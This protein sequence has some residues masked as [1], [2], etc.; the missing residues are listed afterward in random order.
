L[1]PPAFRIDELAKDYR[2]MKH[3]IFDKPL[4]FEEIME[5]LRALEDEI[6]ALE[7]G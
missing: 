5:I 2:A 4:S 6:N 3:M 7:R 1:L